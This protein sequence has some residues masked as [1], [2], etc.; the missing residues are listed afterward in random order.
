M[1]AAEGERQRL[2]AEAAG[3]AAS[4]QTIADA[5]EGADESRSIFRNRAA[6]L[7]LDR[8]SI[9]ATLSL[10]QSPNAKVVVA[11][12]GGSAP[13]NNDALTSAA[14]TGSTLGLAQQATYT[15]PPRG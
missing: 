7:M 8:A 10:A 2:V 1:L 5:L 14:L 3:L 9:A 12:G 6:K 4:I 15:A 11:P 13:N